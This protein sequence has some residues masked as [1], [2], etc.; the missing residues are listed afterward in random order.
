MEFL[1]LEDEKD[2]FEVTMFPGTYREFGPHIDG[3]GPYVV[4]GKV[5]SQYGALSVN[6]R[7]VLPVVP[8]Q[9]L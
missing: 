3:Y 9:S 6:A 5:E 1:T 4:T 8:A 2:V 7:K